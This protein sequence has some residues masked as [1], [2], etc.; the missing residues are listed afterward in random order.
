M[1]GR[2]DDIGKLRATLIPWDAMA[3]V[4]YVMEYGAKKYGDHNWKQV[5]NAR[6][7]YVNAA[8][9]H[10]VAMVDGP[11]YDDESGVHH[12]AHAVCC[13]LFVLWFDMNNTE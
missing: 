11:A 13:L 9:R 7:R 6:E 8:H 10:W 2:K 1:E 3:S 5:P 12:A 4:A